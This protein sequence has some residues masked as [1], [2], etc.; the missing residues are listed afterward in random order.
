MATPR[1]FS[2]SNLGGGGARTPA[3]TPS[4]VTAPSIT[5]P[6]PSYPSASPERMGS[7]SYVAQA[8]KGSESNHHQTAVDVY[9]R[10]LELAGKILEKARTG[11]EIA[12]SEVGHTIDD[13]IRELTFENNELLTMACSQVLDEKSPDFLSAKL[14]NKTI[15][16]VEIG[17]GKRMN[18]S[19]LF[20][21]GMASFLSD[22]GITHVLDIVTKK[23]VLNEEDWSRLRTIS[24]K[25][26]E[27][28]KK[29]P[30][31][32]KVVLTVAEESHERLDG[33]GPMGIKDIKQLDEFSR[34]VA[35]ID[36]FE[37]LTHDRPH[38]PRNLP[39]EAM[40]IILEDGGK[41][42]AD[43]LRLLVD[44]IGIYPVGSWVRLTNKEVAKVVG[45]NPGQPLRP[46]IKV[47]FDERGETLEDPQ[48]VDLS[49]NLSIQVSQPVSD[50]ELKKFVKPVD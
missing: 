33:S 19:K 16:A 36:V 32:N 3:P 31:L 2:F 6:T 37:S 15:L 30:D 1:G 26:V 5:T 49:K 39:H 44:R 21:L 23:E 48:L 9:N 17:I 11:E 13:I 43:V 34:I 46:R 45:S 14:V 4:F 18:K 7:I 42:E 20:Q 25:T 8:I 27:I 12:G 35:V 28:L 38:R 47:L 10:A 40:K 41:F 29:I 22:L 50:D 24:Y